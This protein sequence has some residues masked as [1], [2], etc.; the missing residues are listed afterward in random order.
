MAVPSVLHSLDVFNRAEK[1]YTEH[2]NAINPIV[3]TEKYLLGLELFFFIEYLSPQGKNIPQ[4]NVI[5]SK[6]SP[7]CKIKGFLFCSDTNKS[8]QIKV[9]NFVL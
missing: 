7:P 3:A 1:K 5:L 9:N 8:Q 2:T 6:S 4:S